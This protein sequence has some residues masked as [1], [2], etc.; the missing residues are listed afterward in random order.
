MRLLGFD[1]SFCH[2]IRLCVSTAKFSLL[3]NGSPYGFFAAQRG[4]RQGD[5]MSPALFTFITEILSRLLHREEQAGH[6]S[7]VKVSRTS[8]R[9]S[10]LLYADDLIIYCKAT[11][12]EAACV[13]HCLKT[14]CDWTGQAVSHH[15]S[16][17]HF[18]R[19]VGQ[20]LRREI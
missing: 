6:L 9:V 3:I 4:L 2:L 12:A 15:K 16:S 7:G 11:R 19:N 18:S 20:R 14:F 10:H 17:V 5:P 1:E 8:P 13:A